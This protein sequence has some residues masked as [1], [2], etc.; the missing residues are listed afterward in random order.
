MDWTFFYLIYFVT[1]TIGSSAYIIL[2]RKKLLSLNNK[3]LVVSLFIQF[4]IVYRIINSPIS[5]CW[6]IL[7]FTFFLLCISSGL[8]LLYLNVKRRHLKRDD[9]ITPKKQ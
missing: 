1:M 8:I 6:K 2:T 7:N 9:Q 4:I 5:N 3:L